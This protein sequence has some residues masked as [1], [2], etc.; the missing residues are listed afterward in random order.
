MTKNGMTSGRISKIH[1]KLPGDSNVK[2]KVNNVKASAHTHSLLI[3]SPLQNNFPKQSEFIINNV[4]P[5]NKVNTFETTKALNASA[6]EFIISIGSKAIAARGVFNIVLSGGSTPL[7]VYALLAQPSFCNRID[8]NRTFVFWGDER[9]VSLDDERNNA[10]MANLLLFYKVKISSANIYR[11]PV[12]LAPEEAAKK[13]EDDLIDL[14]G[15]QKIRFDLVLLG[16]GENGHTASLFP[17]TKVADDQTE[18]V[19]EVYIEE[20]KMF[21]VTMTAPMINRARTILFLVTGEHKAEML[22]KVFD[23]S[24]QADKIPAQLINPL[25]GELYWFVDSNAASLV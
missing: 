9:C 7:W 12:D 13:Y 22:K 16:L 8:W 10:H 24:F 23:L 18:G 19:R 15:N 3:K 14:F 6:A 1:Y 2:A 21:R 5:C 25:E 11:I 17:G 20:E 4:L